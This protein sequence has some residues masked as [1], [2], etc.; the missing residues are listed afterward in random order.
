MKINDASKKPI[1]GVT[2]P[3]QARG[4]KAVARSESAAAS[5]RV[6]ISAQ[7]AAFA[8]EVGAGSAV[9]DSAKVAEIKAAIANG[10]FKVNAERIAD[11]LIDTV[12]DLI[13]HR[14]A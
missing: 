8:G 5:D 11:G 10:S 4:G 12:K 13:H 1:D 7:S 14:K 2:T 6:Q 9:F 3:A